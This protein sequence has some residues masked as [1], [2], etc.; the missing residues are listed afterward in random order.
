M[1]STM[2]LSIVRHV[3]IIFLTYH[4]QFW[5][6]Y[7]LRVLVV[8][9]CYQY[10]GYGIG[11]ATA[12]GIDGSVDDK[13]ASSLSASGIV[14]GIFLFAA[15]VFVRFAR[16][17][18]FRVPLYTSNKSSESYF[19]FSVDRKQMFLS[20]KIILLTVL[21]CTTLIFSRNCEYHRTQKIDN[22]HS[23]SHIFLFC[24]DSHWNCN[25]EMIYWL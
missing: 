17:D 14:S 6:I 13:L 8:W 22:K 16:S 20:R 3:W 10:L 18:W 12:D 7:I 1:V 24:C 11:K 15:C 9:C 25:L 23:F 21:Y 2:H 19:D 4:H 5:Y